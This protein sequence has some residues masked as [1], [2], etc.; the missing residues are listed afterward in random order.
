MQFFAL[1]RRRTES[2]TE[3]QFAE[4]LDEEAA[5]VRT[6]YAEGLIRAA[7]SRSDVLGAVILLE[8]DD[9]PSAQAL[10]DSLPLAARGML[11]V[12]LIPVK[13]YRGFS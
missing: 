9:A 4:F 7:Y 6:L 13:P 11:E 12:R 8:V 2:F 10:V 1:A 3:A 5:R